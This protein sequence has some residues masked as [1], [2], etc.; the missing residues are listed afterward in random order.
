[1]AKKMCEMFDNVQ[2]GLQV[3]STF[4][5][6]GIVEALAASVEPGKTTATDAAPQESGDMASGA[7][8]WNEGLLGGATRRRLREMIHNWAGSLQCF[9]QNG[10]GGNA[11][12]TETDGTKNYVAMTSAFS[13]GLRNVMKCLPKWNKN[14]SE[15]SKSY[16]WLNVRKLPELYATPTDSEKSDRNYMPILV[17]NVSFKGTQPATKEAAATRIEMAV[18][19]AATD[20]NI[21][22]AD[23]PILSDVLAYAPSTIEEY[24]PNGKSNCWQLKCGMPTEFAELA[25]NGGSGVLNEDTG[26]W[27]CKEGSGDF[28]KSLKK[29]LGQN[30][31]IAPIIYQVS[32]FEPRIMK[33][34][35]DETRIKLPKNEKAEDSVYDEELIQA[36]RSGLGCFLQLVKVSGV[37]EMGVCVQIREHL[38]EHGLPVKEVFAVPTIMAPE[39]V[40]AGALMSASRRGPEKWWPTNAEGTSPVQKGLFVLLQDEDGALDVEKI[41]CDAKM[42]DLELSLVIESGGVEISLPLKLTPLYAAGKGNVRAVTLMSKHNTPS[43]LGSKMGLDDTIAGVVVIEMPGGHVARNQGR[44]V[45]TNQA[46]WIN[47]AKACGW[48]N[49]RNSLTAFRTKLANS[50]NTNLKLWREKDTVYN[51]WCEENGDIKVDVLLD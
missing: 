38:L 40:K 51:S 48:L 43:D 24:E 35:I 32:Q 44:T 37:T 14:L 2:G 26:E 7:G 6:E 50:V 36:A 39:V 18:R 33:L 30:V 16:E 10:S 34:E 19:L 11:P 15:N 17:K 46:Y 3:T 13:A 5:S 9:M 31:L 42:R 8:V 23:G 20:A 21:S 29:Q 12:Y 45:P 41:L 49:P 4:D 22:L 47:V 27:T 28:L 1:M 25:W